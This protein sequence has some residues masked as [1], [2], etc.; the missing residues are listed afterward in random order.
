[1]TFHRKKL[2]FVLK[3]EESIASSNRAMRRQH[4]L[5][6]FLRINTMCK[7]YT[8]AETRCAKSIQQSAHSADNA[9]NIDIYQNARVTLKY[10]NSAKKIA[11]TRFFF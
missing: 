8:H 7:I 1:M 9:D 2:G 4:A 5:L 11:A 3:Y 10:C 6:K